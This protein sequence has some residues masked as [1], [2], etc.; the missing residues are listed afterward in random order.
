MSYVSENTRNL[1]ITASV[2]RS[3]MLADWK[4]RIAS[5]ETVDALAI[6]V[7]IGRLASMLCERAKLTVKEQDRKPAHAHLEQA[8]AI[9]DRK[10]W[11]KKTPDGDPAYRTK[12]EQ[13]MFAAADIFF[14]RGLKEIDVST[15]ETRGRKVAK[16]TAPEVAPIADAPI[17]NAP[18]TQEPAGFSIPKMTIPKATQAVDLGA[19]IAFLSQAA[20]KALAEAAS[21]TGDDAMR[22]RDAL[23]SI[24][25]IA[26]EFASP[27]PTPRRDALIAEFKA[28]KRPVQPVEISN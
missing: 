23:A 10:V 24:V 15:G 16:V 28:R 27:K 20:T 19:I 6:D 11:N 14:R 1:V 17:V 26:N 18:I 7:I 5:G 21:V 25:D 9:W 8:S 13:D 2:S 12:D 3:A 4:A 22:A